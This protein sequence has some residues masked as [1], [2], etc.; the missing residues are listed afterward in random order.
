LVRIRWIGALP[1]VVALLAAAPAFGAS[2]NVTNFNNKVTAIYE[3]GAG[4]V[5]HVVVTSSGG[6]VTFTD[7]GMNIAGDS[8]CTGP[9]TNTI[10]C[11]IDGGIEALRVDVEDGADSATN[12]TAL[13]ST[14]FGGEV[15][16]SNHDVLNGGSVRDVLFGG[17]GNDTLS[18]N[19]GN[20]GIHGEGNSDTLFGN[21]GNDTIIGD[22]QGD[23]PGANT[24]SGGD[25]NDTLIATDEPTG[26]GFAQNLSGGN[27]NDFLYGSDGADTLNGNAGIDLL[28]PGFD[29]SA[30]VL[31]G[32]ADPDIADY[33]SNN[34]SYPVKVS[35]DNLANDGPTQLTTN[36]NV[37]SDIETV[38]GSKF[39]DQLVGTSGPQNLDG[40]DGNDL[41]DGGTGPDDLNGGVGTDRVT[42]ASRVTPVTVTIDGVAND[43][44]AGENDNVELNVENLTGGQHDDTLTG[45]GDSNQLDGGDGGDQLNGLGGADTLN[46]EGSNDTF[47]ANTGAD[48]MNGGVGFDTADYSARAVP[49]NVSLDS[50]ANDGS[51]GEADNVD[52]ERV[53][54]GQG[55]D[56]LT[57]DANGNSLEG[58]GA[59]DTV[60]GGGGVDV[61]DGG[62]GIDTIQGGDGGDIITNGA[63]AD[64]ADSVT[65]G[66]G[67]D[68][69][70]YATRTN[71]VN[72][73][74]DDVANDGEVGE[75]DDVKSSVEKV[76]GGSAADVLTGSAADNVLAGGGA[77]D[78]IAA[79]AGDDTLNGNAGVDSMFGGDN[80][81]T[82]QGGT[83]ADTMGGGPGIDKADYSDALT[84]ID[85]TLDDV[86]NDGV[87][88]EGDNVSTTIENVLGG[89]FNDTIQGDGDPNGLIGGLGADTLKGAP[90]SDV[91]TGGSGTD[92]L[93][94]GAGADELH[95]V[96]ATQDTLLCGPEVDSYA[97]DG[98][99]AVGNDCENALP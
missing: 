93:V 61:L 14:M 6:A 73:S 47:I 50:Q 8:H 17:N 62:N 83:G 38:W 44:V 13:P 1:L 37:K 58:R 12:N 49:Q 78:T 95:A 90:G 24:L 9:G 64:G 60:S 3:A 2:A 46:G 89:R 72:V 79:G 81:D 66:P 56:Q 71:P 82:L 19:G 30:D 20:D 85:V 53:F 99:D 42:Y 10:T 51:A 29:N 39:D 75:N 26:N 57:G 55:P 96:D 98:I 59:A 87:P 28:S 91:I 36:D 69:S 41:L 68:L 31:S 80:H 52:V 33:L 40:F 92:S 32:G 67:I 54:G 23:P 76:F 94:G 77:G 25:Q 84:G 88:A 43:G 86:A 18:G 7:P 65:G 27:G 11:R 48:V 74:L 4:E 35:L 21:A 5:N 63:A 16:D 70:N 34:S 15:L 45:D 97:A 22:D